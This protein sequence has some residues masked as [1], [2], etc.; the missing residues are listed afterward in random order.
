MA[1]HPTIALRL[2]SMLPQIAVT[3]FTIIASHSTLASLHSMNLKRLLPLLIALTLVLVV[4]T[5]CATG[6][7]LA[8][9]KPMAK[10]NPETGKMEQVPGNKGAYAGVPVAVALDVASAPFMGLFLLFA[11]ATGFRG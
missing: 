3:R 11:W 6:S 2:Q 7:L 1:S 9:T 10:C 8:E 5:G 4:G